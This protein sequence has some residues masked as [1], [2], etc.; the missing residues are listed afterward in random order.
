MRVK[1]THTLNTPHPT[2]KLEPRPPN[3]PNVKAVLLE[4]ALVIQL[5]FYREH[6]YFRGFSILAATLLAYKE[7]HVW[8]GVHGINSQLKV[9]GGGLCGM[10]WCVGGL[11]R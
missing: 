6:Q 4:N 9:R 7:Q 5:W 1:K 11:G 10:C 8:V 3:Q 2:A